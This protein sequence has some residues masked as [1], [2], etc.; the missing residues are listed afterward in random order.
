MERLFGNW[1]DSLTLPTEPA[2]SVSVPTT[3]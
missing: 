2:L 3:Q 1:G